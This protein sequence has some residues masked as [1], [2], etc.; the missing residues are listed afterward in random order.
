M[1]DMNIEQRVKQ[2]FAELFE[3]E[4]DEIE[5]TLEMDDVKEWDSLMHIQLI[6]A[7]EKEFSIK[8]TTQQI[9]DMK[10]IAAIIEIIQQKEEK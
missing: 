2:V 6:L 1:N 4:L 9:L 5:N 8:F 3:K 7:L 10:S